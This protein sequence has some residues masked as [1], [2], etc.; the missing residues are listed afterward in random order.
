MLAASYLAGTITVRSFMGT[1]SL[2]GAPSL[3]NEKE[4]V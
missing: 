1:P 4:P 3:A 2:G